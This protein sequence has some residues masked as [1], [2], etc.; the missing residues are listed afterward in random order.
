MREIITLQAG[1][2]ANLVGAD[3][4]RLAATREDALRRA[5]GAPRLLLFDTRPALDGVNASSQADGHAEGEEENVLSWEG[6]VMQIQRHLL[7]PEWRDLRLNDRTSVAAPEPIDAFAQGRAAYGACDV[8]E[9]RLRFFAEECDALQGFHLLASPSDGF[10]G[11]AAA[12]LGDIRDDYSKTSVTAFLTDVPPASSSGPL[13]VT[14]A[15]N[16]G[17]TLAHIHDDASLVVPLIAASH[18]VSATALDAV[19]A[20]YRRHA[21][22]DFT[23]A[24][25]CSLLTWRR[26]ARLALARLALAT[27]LTRALALLPHEPP[28]DAD[29]YAES[30]VLRG[31]AIDEETLRRDAQ[32]LRKMTVLPADSASA[33]LFARLQATTALRP[34]LNDI[35]KDFEAVP[36]H[37][38]GDTQ[39][40]DH[41]ETIEALQTIED[42]L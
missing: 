15:L 30:V 11:L 34:F 35:V 37:A 24:A 5:D 8:W 23:M 13:N 1:H 39:R 6:D 2:T 33:P 38:I 7:G 31:V 17:L 21:V 18:S 14:R 3:F 16:M 10:G 26:G 40:D 22:N 28:A 36:L 4:W 32:C 27:D 41:R 19:T 9:E 20:P 42:N 29:V 12:L 25:Q